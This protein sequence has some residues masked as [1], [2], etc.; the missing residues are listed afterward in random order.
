MKKG[1]LVEILCLLACIFLITYMIFTWK[2]ISPER[3]SAAETNVS[4]VGSEGG[5]V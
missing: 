4:A 5:E 1:Y 2:I 3:E